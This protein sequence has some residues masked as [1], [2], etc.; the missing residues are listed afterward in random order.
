MWN[1]LRTKPSPDE[2]LKNDLSALELR[3]E[4]LRGE[5]LRWM[6]KHEMRATRERQGEAK[7][8]NGP[9]PVPDLPRGV[10]A[11]RGYLSGTPPS[12]HGDGGPG[13][14]PPR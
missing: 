2:Q 3:F 7:V 10:L 9:E 11:R 5:I 13:P 14:V 8:A 1:W 6:K 4:E 12:Q